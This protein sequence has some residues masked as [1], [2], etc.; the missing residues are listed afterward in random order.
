MMLR[1]P[2]QLAE[3]GFHSCIP[4]HCL[5]TGSLFRNISFSHIHFLFPESLNDCSWRWPSRETPDTCIMVGNYPST[6]HKKDS[7][8]AIFDEYGYFQAHAGVNHGGSKFLT[9][10]KGITGEAAV[11]FTNTSLN[12]MVQEKIKT[13]LGSS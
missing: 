3:L 1:P 7:T 10:P 5:S 4:L 9:F 2:N 13:R 8:K 12:N 11:A 6:M